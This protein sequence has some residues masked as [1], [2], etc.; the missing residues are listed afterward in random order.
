MHAQEGRSK[1]V[2]PKATCPFFLVPR[3]RNPPSVNCLATVRMRDCRVV[4]PSRRECSTTGFFNREGSKD[5]P[6]RQL[7]GRV[8]QTVR[9]QPATYLPIVAVET[10]F[11]DQPGKLDNYSVFDARGGEGQ[12]HER[13]PGASWTKVWDVLRVQWK[14]SG[15]RSLRSCMRKPLTKSQTSIEYRAT[16]NGASVHNV[17]MCRSS[18]C[19]GYCSR[20]KTQNFSNKLQKALIE[21]ENRGY[22]SYFYTLTIQSGASIKEQQTLLA[23][24]YRSFTKEV[25][26]KARNSGVKCG[27]A[28][29][30]DSTFSNNNDYSCHLHI[31]GLMICEKEFIIEKECFSIWE[32]SVKA[33]SYSGY[34]VSSSAFYLKEVKTGEAKQV[35]RYISK[36]L[37]SSYEISG[38][39]GKKRGF[40]QL[41]LDADKN[42]NAFKVYNEYVS[43]FFKVHYSSTGKFISSLIGEEEEKEEE[44]EELSVSNIEEGEGLSIKVPPYIHSIFCDNDAIVPFLELMKMYAETDMLKCVFLE[45]WKDVIDN[46]LYVE[47]LNYLQLLMLVRQL[48]DTHL[49][50]RF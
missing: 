14:G 19:A 7:R 31:H 17:F 27:F 36:F 11:A 40:Y 13:E 9:S 2:E 24:A 33:N 3:K 45:G 42:E 12:E 20:I 37:K 15:S 10:A 26:R 16:E 44:Q 30:Y 47:G 18:V 49:G 23:K 38:S 21:A 48:L 35:S 6:P 29:Q 34:Y 1:G 32:R 41:V 22:K 39:S 46:L 25:S 5:A 43:C 28:F 50:F 8:L 4:R